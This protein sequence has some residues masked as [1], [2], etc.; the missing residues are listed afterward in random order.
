MIDRS[1]SRI[2]RPHKP[3][4][5]T[6]CV[7]NHLPLCTNQRR[8][9]SLRQV[10][11]SCILSAFFPALVCCRLSLLYLALYAKRS[12]LPWRIEILQ[13]SPWRLHA[14]CCAGPTLTFHSSRAVTVVPPA[15][16]QKFCSSWIPL[17][18]HR[19]KLERDPVRRDSRMHA[20]VIDDTTTNYEALRGPSGPAD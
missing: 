13:C 14:R 7:R 8:S 20:V 3:S 12:Q 10:C 1:S 17:A 2:Q 9:L 5:R 19:R 16:Y 4:T 6:N 18:L 11:I 15:K